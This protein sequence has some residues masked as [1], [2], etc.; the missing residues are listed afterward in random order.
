MKQMWRKGV[1]MFLSMSLMLS[2]LAIPALAAESYEAQIDGT[3]YTTL[4]DAFEAADSDETI[5]LL[6]NCDLGADQL[7]LE[8]GRN[9]TIDL[10]G[11][12]IT[13][14]DRLIEIKHGTLTLTGQ[15]TLEETS[16]NYAPVILSGS[17]DD[18]AEDY[19]VLNVGPD[20]TLKGWA[21]VFITTNKIGSSPSHAYGVVVNVA[22][23]I[24]SVKDQGGFNG[25][26]IYLNGQ[27]ADSTGPVPEINIAS[28]A[29]FTATG[30]G[31]YAAGYGVWNIENGAQLTGGSTGIEIRAGELNIAGGT[32]TGGN[33]PL[34]VNPNG[35]G[36]TVLNSALAIAQHTTK[37]PIKVNITGGSFEGTAALN[38]TNPQGNDPEDLARIEVNVEGG[39]FY[40]VVESVLTDYP[41]I[42][43]GSFDK[44]PSAL[45]PEGVAIT[46]IDG[47]WWVGDL[48]PA[49]DED[50]DSS[51]EH[52]A[53][54]A[55]EREFWE[56]LT[57]ELEE[58]TTQLAE[59]SAP[60]A[61]ATGTQTQP[62]S[63]PALSL[64]ATSYETIP[65]WAVD[66]LARQNATLK[67]TYIDAEGKVQ[68]VE[69]DCATILKTEPNRVFFRIEDFV[70]RYAPK[71]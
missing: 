20:V 36:S 71:N 4:K 42:K 38:V 25:A 40:G 35:N 27:N 8:D 23:K 46:E 18:E 56:S 52:A 37:L 17:V 44:D 64:D 14:S 53:Q 21:G 62:V 67:L 1:T 63:K 11:F 33:G 41:F 26:C 15:G 22:G 3:S 28:T 54:V 5:T 61:P 65:Y 29:E 6:A 24:V 59:A 7:V 39:A 69:I 9:V 32:I 68:T 2:V 16:P 57:E 55:A 13:R 47:L 19:T 50:D 66:A 43:G 58:L 34:T 60:E 70:E 49:P 48:P 31:I 12:N 51:E 45:V 30:N 10:N